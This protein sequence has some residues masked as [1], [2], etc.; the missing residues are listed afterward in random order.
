MK[1]YFIMGLIWEFLRFCVL[2][3]IFGRTVENS[4]VLWFA[5]Q[6]LVLFYFYIFL[7]YNR[8]KYCQY[9]KAVVA[10]KVIGIAAGSFYLTKTIIKNL[11]TTT[12]FF[13]LNIL[14]IDIIIT[15]LMFFLTKKYFANSL[16]EENANNTNCQR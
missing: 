11:F 12:V 1:I 5:S 13:T 14:F 16:R 4:A 3:F 7:C 9:L 15:V 10:G 2:F 8:D 6:Q